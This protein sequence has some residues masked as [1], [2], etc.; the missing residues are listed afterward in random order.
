MQSEWNSFHPWMSISPCFFGAR[1]PSPNLW[2][3]NQ[4]QKPAAQ[5]H[6]RYQ[7]LSTKVAQPSL[8]LNWGGSPEF[9]PPVSTYFSISKFLSHLFSGTWEQTCRTPSSMAS[10]EKPPISAGWHLA[11]S[12]GDLAQRLPK[13]TGESWQGAG[14][15]GAGW[16]WD[17]MSWIHLAGDTEWFF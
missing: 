2:G 17:Q 1:A 4:H 10:L 15:H 3:L 12:S 9:P 5:W 7:G 6:Q 13:C 16:C 14:G 8:Y 11:A